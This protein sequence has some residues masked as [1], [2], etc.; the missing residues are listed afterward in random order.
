[1]NVDINECDNEDHGGMVE[2]SLVRKAERQNAMGME[3]IPSINTLRMTY[4][5]KLV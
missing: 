2:V 4:M 1:M 3:A 5:I